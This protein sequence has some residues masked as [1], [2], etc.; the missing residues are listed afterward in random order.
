MDLVESEDDVVDMTKTSVKRLRTN[1]N[2][3]ASED[4]KNNNVADTGR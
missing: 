4:R 3:N 2:T 1:H